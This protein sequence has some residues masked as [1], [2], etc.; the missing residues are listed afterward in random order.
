MEPDQAG[1]GMVA[2]GRVTRFYAFLDRRLGSGT[3]GY[4]IPRDWK[5]GQD[6]HKQTFKRQM[7]GVTSSL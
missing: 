2:F 5:K 6:A 1:T 4:E 7:E 3:D